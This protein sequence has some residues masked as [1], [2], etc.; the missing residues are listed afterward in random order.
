MQWNSGV[1]RSAESKTFVTFAAMLV[2][3]RARAPQRSGRDDA[4]PFRH[5]ARRDGVRRGPRVLGRLPFARAW[6]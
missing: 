5:R 2:A 1:V 6:R 4:A 3:L